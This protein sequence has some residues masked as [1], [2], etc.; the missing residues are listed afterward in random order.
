VYDKK[1][2]ELI[3]RGL[4]CCKDISKCR[5]ETNKDCPFRKSDLSCDREKLMDDAREAI[6]ELERIN[7]NISG[8]IRSAMVAL[9]ADC[10]N[11]E[12]R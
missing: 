1:R 7:D 8:M 6:E 12:Y 11:C 9:G 2:R 4:A 3:K 5:Y 10:D